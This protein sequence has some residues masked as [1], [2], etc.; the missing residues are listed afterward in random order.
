M[1]CARVSLTL[2]LTLTLTLEWYK[3]TEHRFIAVFSF[4]LFSIAVKCDHSLLLMFHIWSVWASLPWISGGHPKKGICW[5]LPCLVSTVMHL[6]PLVLF[7]N[8]SILKCSCHGGSLEFIRRA[9][10]HSLNLQTE[11]QPHAASVHAARKQWK[12]VYSRM[13]H[14]IKDAAS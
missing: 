13:A 3:F 4:F 1:E 2:T 6:S 14:R 5:V 7:I 11:P 9:L 10:L 8:G 12:S